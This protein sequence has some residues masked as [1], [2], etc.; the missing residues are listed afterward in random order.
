MPF[1]IIL[2]QILILLITPIGFLIWLWWG[3]SES[4]LDWLLKL[5][6]VSSILLFIILIGRWDWF[7]YYFRSG[8]V[9]L[10]T[11]TSF[12]SYRRN[13]KDAPPYVGGDRAKW[14]YIAG[15]VFILVI[16]SFMVTSAARGY[17]YDGD[18]VALSFPLKDGTFYVSNGGNAQALN[19]HYSS[20]TQRYAL[21]IGK[22]DPLGARAN[23]ISP[24]ELDDYA[25]FGD[26]VYSPCSGTITAAIDGLP[27]I[28]PGPPSN[29]DDPA[30]NHVVIACH[31]IKVL[32][33]HLIKGSVLL[34]E[35]DTV[36]DGEP[37]GKVGNSGNTSEPH[38][39]IHAATG[40]SPGGALDGEAV[41]I[42]F[43]GRFLA[44]NT[45]FT[46]D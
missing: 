8:L 37:V 38:L 9:L 14:A 43:D 26:T 45:V 39:H 44:R 25:I 13:A 15:Y 24:K 20:T 23:G 6:I 4:K 21:D 46:A 2:I 7:S 30:G 31:G 3:R 42:R 17:F 22:L 27:D 16:F 10:L 19:G 34:E 35:G 28:E 29:S 5:L 41:A 36:M 1:I 11:I 32:L 33:A 40:A 18:S 12:L